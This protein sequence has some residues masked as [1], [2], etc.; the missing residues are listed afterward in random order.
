MQRTVVLSFKN[1]T[2]RGLVVFSFNVLLK[3]DA[4]STYLTHKAEVDALKPIAEAYRDAFNAASTN[5]ELLNMAKDRKMLE[6]LKQLEVVAYAV[7][8]VA[9][10]DK[11]YIIG[12][13]FA[14]RKDVQA[15][16]ELPAPNNFKVQNH[17]RNGSL[18]L[19]WGA[20]ANKVNY[21]VEMRV[22]GEE[23]W[24]TIA[25]PTAATYT[26]NDLT[27]GI[28]LEFRVR[29]TGTKNIMG[30]WTRIIDIYVD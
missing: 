7:D 13:G 18:T 2:Q 12:A 22:V 14:V 26:V 17:E 10:G 25:L 16:N 30:D 21:V 29:A 11:A 24:Q 19:K 28:H 6:L 15:L 4:V 8:D 9:N 1:E 3:M 5:D 23:K 20:V 27:R